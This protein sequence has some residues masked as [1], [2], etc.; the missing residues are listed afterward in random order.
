MS[1][2]VTATHP[3]NTAAHITFPEATRWEIDRHGCLSVVDA[4]TAIPK[5]H[6]VGVFPPDVWLYVVAD[7][8]IA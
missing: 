2:R 8:E 1:I 4:S 6:T 7:Q 3:D 5:A